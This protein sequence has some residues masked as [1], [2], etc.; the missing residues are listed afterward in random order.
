MAQ[1]RKNTAIVTGATGDIGGAIARKLVNEGY[2]VLATGRKARTGNALVKELGKE[3]AAF[4]AADIT[5]DEE[6]KALFK[7]NA[8]TEHTLTLVVGCAGVLKMSSADK[9][10]CADWE[11]TIAT[12]LSGVA[13]LF[14][15]AV[16]VMKKKKNGML[17]AIGSRW[18]ESGAVDASAYA[19]SKSALR[20]YIASLQLELKNTGV[21]P[22]LISPGSVA[23]RMS[24][25]VDS[26]SVNK[27]ISTDDVASLI[28]YVA[29][30]PSNVIFDE[31]KIKAYPYDFTG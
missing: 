8:V 22:I 18:G 14:R 16:P 13:S 7:H 5:R 4:Q 6:V 3:N 11:K 20:A 30:T 28:A 27:Y 31:L 1:N 9:I 10:S 19:A 23:G 29:S 25:S 17:V 24:E 15:Y 2:F 21:R 26:R 12:N